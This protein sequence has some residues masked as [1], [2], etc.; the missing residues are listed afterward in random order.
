[1]RIAVDK[2]GNAWV[3]NDAG[4]IYMYNVASKAWEKK[5]ASS[6]GATA[7]SVHTGA[8]S[9]TVW[10]LGTASIPGGFPI[11]Q[12]D[13]VK[14]SWEPYGTYGAVEITEAA[15]VP[16]IVQSDGKVVFQSL[17]ANIV[18]TGRYDADVASANTSGAAA[19]SGVRS[20]AKRFAPPANATDLRQHQGRLCRKVH[21]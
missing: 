1:M 2:G 14:E 9:G 18:D 8:S 16:W 19:D 6:T 7:R 12:W 13:S 3:V 17:A 20:R 10:M 15:G 21:S 4:E 11:F 5:P